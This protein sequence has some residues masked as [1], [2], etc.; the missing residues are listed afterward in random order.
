M[1]KRNYKKAVLKL[2]EILGLTTGLVVFIVAITGCCW[3]FKDEIQALTQDEF[4]IEP[5]NA[6]MLKASEARKMAQTVFPDKNIHGTLYKK[7]TDAIEVIFYE[8]EPEFYQ[9]VHLHPTTGKVLR[10]DNHEAG[11]FHFVLDGHM[12][13]WLP[14]EIG[15]HVVSISVLIF[16]FILGSGLYLWWPK[17]NNRKQRLSFAWSKT[18][19]WRRRNFDLHAIAG[20]YVF[21]L[22]FALAFTGCVMAFDWFYYVVYKSAG[23]ERAPQFI[24]PKNKDNSTFK[25][26]GS[27]LP[28]DRLIPILQDQNPNANSFEIH[29]PATDSTSIYVEVTY[30][31]GVYYSSDYRFFDQTTLEEVPTPSI[32][33]KY[34]EASFADKIIRMNYDI[35]V[36]AIGGLAGKII[37]FF[38]SLITATLPITGFLL[39]YGRRY[40][41][42]SRSTGKPSAIPAQSF[43]T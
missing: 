33:G 17:K 4:Y 12:T 18:T 9:S 3:V 28:M 16:L 32:Y 42:A 25:Q 14:D 40:K 26:V 20:F 27:D 37:A 15:G 11:F 30:Q 39:W 6:P 34:S 24:I 31:E 36:G 19:R 2:H 41:S 23:G 1:P 35:H 43:G 7:K 38:I 13:L 5:S 22:A 29:Y 10:V 8:Y 21:A